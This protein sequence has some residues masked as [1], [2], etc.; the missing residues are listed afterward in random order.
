MKHVK[1]RPDCWVQLVGRNDDGRA[2]LAI[3]VDIN[4]DGQCRVHDHYFLLQA[5]ANNL[6]HLDR[7]LSFH[8]DTGAT[9][10]R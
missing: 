4:V 2:G 10:L 3:S 8:V 1:H 9:C 5:A 7:A 6:Y